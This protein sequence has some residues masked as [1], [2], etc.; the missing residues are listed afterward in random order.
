MNKFSDTL[1]CGP[2]GLGIVKS[3]LRQNEKAFNL[4]NIYCF[5]SLALLFFTLPTENHVHKPIWCILG[6]N[7]CLTQV[8][9]T[10]VLL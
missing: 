7:K 1:G 9:M 10:G 8:L 3:I 2:C 4:I 5:T 6:L